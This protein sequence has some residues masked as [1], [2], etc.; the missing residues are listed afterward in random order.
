MIVR[1]SRWK[2][3]MAVLSDNALRDELRRKGIRI[4]NDLTNRQAALVTEAKKTVKSAKSRR[5]SWWWKTDGHL[6]PKLLTDRNKTR[7]PQQ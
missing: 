2:D 5:E 3:K 1:F 6:A 4:A 7:Q